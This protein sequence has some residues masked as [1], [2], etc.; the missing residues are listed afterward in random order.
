[1]LGEARPFRER[2]ILA[3]WAKGDGR[4]GEV[5][6]VIQKRRGRTAESHGM[7]I[8]IL[9]AAFNSVYAFMCMFA[10]EG[11]AGH[12]GIDIVASLFWGL[13]QGSFPLYLFSLSQ[14]VFALSSSQMCQTNSRRMSC[15]HSSPSG[16]GGPATS[17]PAHPES[18][19][20]MVE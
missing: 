19:Q 13:G 18:A 4:G 6:S 12:S 20:Q 3:S 7:C 5:T 16:G 2:W 11:V 15:V 10:R 14:W 9:A 17:F 1:M 8:C